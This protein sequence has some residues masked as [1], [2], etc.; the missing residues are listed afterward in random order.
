M[1]AYLVILSTGLFI[2][3]R[4]CVSQQMECNKPKFFCSR[5]KEQK[6]ALAAGTQLMN[7]HLFLVSGC[8]TPC[9]N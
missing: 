3:V 6:G 4:L 2:E 7:K 8:R 5:K 9:E 1:N